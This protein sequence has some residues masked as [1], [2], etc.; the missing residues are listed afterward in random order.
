MRAERRVVRKLTDHDTAA[1]L[2]RED[3]QHCGVDFIVI[4]V[5]VPDAY[6]SIY[7]LNGWLIAKV[8]TAR[9]SKY[10]ACRSWI[11]MGTP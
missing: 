7:N 11:C 8:D 10:G 4:N 5:T 3:L 2:P 9:K 1:V 6:I